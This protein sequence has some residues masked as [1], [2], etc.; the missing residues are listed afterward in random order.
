MQQQ[1]A[2]AFRPY[3]VFL[4]QAL[5]GAEKHQVSAVVAWSPATARRF[6]LKATTTDVELAREAGWIV[7]GLPPEEPI[8]SDEEFYRPADRRYFRPER[9]ERHGEQFRVVF[10]DDAPILAGRLKWKGFVVTL[11][12]ADPSAV[13]AS[14]VIQGRPQPVSP[15][16]S[17][18]DDENIACL[19]V[20]VLCREGEV[21]VPDGWRIRTVQPSQPVGRHVTD[22]KGKRYELHEGGVIT[23]DRGKPAGSVRDDQQCV[24]K[25]DEDNSGGRKGWIRL[26]LDEEADRDSGVDPRM[27]FFDTDENEVWA[28]KR[29]QIG[30]YTI[31]KPKMADN[32][33]TVK[34]RDRELFE[35]R[36]KEMPPDDQ[37]FLCLPLD[38]RQL[39]MRQAVVYRLQEAPLEHHRPLLRLFEARDKVYL[40]SATPAPEPE[41][42]VLCD[43]ERSGTDQQ[44]QFVRKALG[45]PDLAVLEGPPGSGKT[46]AICELVLQCIERHQRVLLCATTNYAI[47]NVLERLAD[48][49]K[50]PEVFALRIGRAERVDEK[51]ER[52]RYEARVEKLEQSLRAG[53][54][55]PAGVDVADA[56]R[57]LV[58][59]AA[60]L[61]C[62]TTTGI[63]S[64][65]WLKLSDAELRKH[66]R[67]GQPLFDVLIVDEASKTTIPEFLVPAAF[68]RRWIIVGD[69]RQLAP[70]AD[71]AELVANLTQAQLDEDSNH[72]QQDHK[73]IPENL[74][75]AC[76]VLFELGQLDHCGAK[77]VVVESDPVIQALWDEFTT[78]KRAT[79][80]ESTA[81]E[82]YE[83]LRR[84][85]EGLVVRIVERANGRRDGP[86]L[87]QVEVADLEGGD[88]R[89]LAVSAANVVLVPGP[90]LPRVWRHLPPEACVVP[91]P[92]RLP[93]P[94]EFRHAALLK[95]PLKV[96]PRGTHG[97]PVS[98]LPELER[99][100]A[101]AFAEKT[102]AGE[103]AWRLI[104]QHEL[105]ARPTKGDY[106]VREIAQLEP[107]TVRIGQA[108]ESVQQIALPSIIESLQEG[109][110]S[111]LARRDSLLGVGF[112]SKEA[113]E[114]VKHAWQ[115]R[116]EPL[117]FQHR[118]HPD[119]AAFP[120]ERFYE[121]TRLQDANTIECRDEKL[122]WAP[123]WT[124]PPPARSCWLNVDGRE[125]RGRNLAEVEAIRVK[126][127]EFLAWAE[128]FPPA[129]PDEP[130]WQVAILS[131]YLGQQEALAGMMKN[132]TGSTKRLR[133]EMPN[134]DLVCGTVDRFQ[135]READLV[136][137]SFRNTGR[138]GFLD[139]LNRL[140]VGITRARQ[141][142]VLVGKRE[143][144]KSER[145]RVE[146]LTAL[147]GQPEWR[148]A[149]TN[150]RGGLR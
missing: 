130:R 106:L 85:P 75:R 138:K 10:G 94:F 115:E 38:T 24:F 8:D 62:S 3:R 140:N 111:S 54:T 5:K 68:A 63:L 92:K 23:S 143:Y 96:Q 104:R 149:P 84:G 144:W 43:P 88:P 58:L 150:R 87:R 21:V 100:V 131:F 78:P 82:R 83:L 29:E 107:A 48:E 14:L 136:F 101:K 18:E 39:R 109:V 16:P 120:R 72:S 117:T 125:D 70:F 123:R 81:A 26:E 135:G 128:K 122:G 89:A 13:P 32:I 67:L 102:W 64:H 41:W 11:R 121:G 124:V 142:L 116:F 65:P 56:A 137:L 73:R 98:D 74:Q 66:Q 114:R 6:R 7:D 127:L 53:K 12:E 33:L 17:D 69:K 80:A 1:V 42:R 126:L 119:I 146:E 2:S 99:H 139:S 30:R 35:L 44:R 103:L 60:N 31:R 59:D 147:G 71:R 19:R 110:R 52:F 49:E 76:H 15:V 22:E 145:H 141:Q 91:R 45:T 47:D 113:T 28:I 105:K 77:W 108:I 134:V 118:M 20:K 37:P 86:R 93:V 27:A 133:F 9:I 129:R 51:L 34:D 95:G 50:Y 4:E 112:D 148:S 90:L 97:K 55:L 46:T 40:P 25:C 36:V 79:D 57:K 132:V 61:V